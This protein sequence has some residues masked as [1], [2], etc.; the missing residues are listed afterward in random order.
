MYFPGGGGGRRGGGWR[1]GS[2]IGEECEL[3]GDA[4]ARWIITEEERMAAGGDASMTTGSTRHNG[5]GGGD[6]M[7]GRW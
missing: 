1:D 5:N 2:P 3:C 7:C 6:G 4:Y